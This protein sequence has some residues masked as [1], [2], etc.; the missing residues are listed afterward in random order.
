MVVGTTVH[1]AEHRSADVRVAVINVTVTNVTV[2][3]VTVSDVTITHYLLN[4]C[5]S[6]LSCLTAVAFDATAPV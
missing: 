4:V 1:H 3:N 6:P 5:I 2:T